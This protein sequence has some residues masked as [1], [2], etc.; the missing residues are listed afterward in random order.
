MERNELT[1]QRVPVRITPVDQRKEVRG[2]ADAHGRVLESLLGIAVKIGRDE[3][4]DGRQELGDVGDGVLRLPAMV[5]ELLLGHAGVR[6]DLLPEWPAG[7]LF[8]T[9]R[10]L[11][12]GRLARPRHGWLV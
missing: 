12:D 5:E 4:L 10:R 3:V 6:R 2:N 8:V 9:K 11:V 1:A 7:E